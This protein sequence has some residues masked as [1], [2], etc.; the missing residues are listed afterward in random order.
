MTPADIRAARE[1]GI[2]AIAV[3]TGYFSKEEL[4][5]EKPDYVLKDI[6]EIMSVL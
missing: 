1:N 4:V 5:K 3:A 6:Q 2:I